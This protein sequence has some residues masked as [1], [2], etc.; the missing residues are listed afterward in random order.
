MAHISKLYAC[1]PGLMQHIEHHCILRLASWCDTCNK[2]KA[3]LAS[4]PMHYHYWIC[5]MDIQVQ[6]A[7]LFMQML[8]SNHACTGTLC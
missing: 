7:L 1:W 4:I 3:N 2:Q 5:G 6:L 8:L